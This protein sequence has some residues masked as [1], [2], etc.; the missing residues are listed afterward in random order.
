M[1]LED[2]EQL[3]FLDALNSVSPEA[4]KSSRS[5]DNVDFKPALPKNKMEAREE[6]GIRKATRS[7]NDLLN[8]LLE[9]RENEKVV[10]EKPPSG[11]RRVLNA[12]KTPRKRTK[13]VDLSS[14]SKDV[15]LSSRYRMIRIPDKLP[16]GSGFEAR[17]DEETDSA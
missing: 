5:D 12:L 10:L 11:A 4:A 13:E 8:A 6:R 1:N 15:D 3:S 16:E 17:P 14:R 2:D 9:E 7:Q